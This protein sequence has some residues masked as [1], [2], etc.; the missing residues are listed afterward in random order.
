MFLKGD[1]EINVAAY[2]DRCEEMELDEKYSGFT[3]DELFAEYNL[4]KDI[5]IKHQL[6]LRYVY[7]VRTV[8]FQMRGVYK[9]FA[10]IDDI[11][12]EGVIM[13][14]N[15]IDK[16]DASKNVKFE[17]YISKRVRGLVIDIARKYDWVPRSVRKNAKDIDE[18]INQLHI[19]L[20]RAPSDEEIA[21]YLEISLEKYNEDIAKANLMN[22]ISFEMLLDESG[23]QK[24]T[25]KSINGK[26][27]ISPEGHM[28]KLELAKEIKRGLETLRENEKLVISLHYMQELNMKEIAVVLGVSEPRIS[29]VH[30][31]ALKKLRVFL[32]DKL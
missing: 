12:N 26:M 21:Q 6:V 22:V 11:V 27:P 24:N 1:T 16:F 25:E 30:S 7:I 5:N 4:T 32:K 20:G 8:A 31:N 15:S 10:Q 23:I 9:D 17:S 2:Y 28:D 13:L 19:K 18:A 14:M 3:N 29:Q